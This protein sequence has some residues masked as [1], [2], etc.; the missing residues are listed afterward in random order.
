MY[1][2]FK[3]YFIDIFNIFIKYFLVFFMNKILYKNKNNKKIN[4]ELFIIMFENKFKLYNLLF[5]L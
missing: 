1:S 5:F 3:I 4:I 2:Y